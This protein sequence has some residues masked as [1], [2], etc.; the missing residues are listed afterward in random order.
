MFENSPKIEFLSQMQTKNAW[1][2][3]KQGLQNGYLGFF[4]FCFFDPKNVKKSLFLGKWS[5]NPKFSKLSKT[6]IHV[7]E[8]A[9]FNQCAKFQLDTI[10][11]D[12]K[13]DVFVFPIVPNDDVIHLNAIFWEL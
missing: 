12:P 8:L 7:V 3:E 13:R 2:I 4:K 11:F 1:Y 6:G 10:I 9:V 5:Q